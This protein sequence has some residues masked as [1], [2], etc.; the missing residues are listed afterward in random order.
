M[1]RF[2][3]RIHPRCK[4][5]DY[6]TAGAYFV[7]TTTHRRWRIFGS[8]APDGIQLNNVGRIVH[9]CWMTVADDFHGVRIDSFVVMPNHVHAIVVL[10]DVPC[11]TATLSAVV[12][13]AKQHASHEIARL[14][15]GPRPPIWQRSFHDRI[16]RDARALTTIRAYI[17]NN[18]ARAWANLRANS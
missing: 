14:P 9:R 7:T 17:A 12:G 11:R 10:E 18:P 16:I 8:P 13:A 4:W 3:T 2:Y 1:R 15:R 5:Y 6:A